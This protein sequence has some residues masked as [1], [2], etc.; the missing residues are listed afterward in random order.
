MTKVPVIE[1]HGIAPDGTKYVLNH[2]TNENAAV[3]GNN[4][5]DLER[6]LNKLRDLAKSYVMRWHHYLPDD[7][8][9]VVEM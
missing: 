3:S 4:P 7:K 2:L 5:A 9:E 1:I 6:S 8:I